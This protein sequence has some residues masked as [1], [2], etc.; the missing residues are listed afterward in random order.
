MRGIDNGQ[1]YALAALPEWVVER[2]IGRLDSRWTGKIELDIKDGQILGIGY[3]ERE[4]A[5]RS[6][7]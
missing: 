3:T 2:I 7:H 1:R 6:D 4:R 5:P